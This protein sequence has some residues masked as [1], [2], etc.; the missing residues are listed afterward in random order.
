MTPATEQPTDRISRKGLAA[1]LRVD[2]RTITNLAKEGMPKLSPGWFSLAVCI[3]WYVERER[4]RAR[5]SKGLNELDLARQR[6]TLAE[7]ERVELEL[8]RERG[9]QV[10]LDTFRRFVDDMGTR[11]R[12]RLLAAPGLYS[13]RTVNCQSLPESQ[14]AW[15]A[16][17]RDVLADLATI[18][19]A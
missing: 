4:E 17:V 8:V 2:E 6:K 18:I 5:A 7:A 11:V 14:R 13:P 9:E 10:P 3:P 1:L 19:A 12:A 15:E 16:A